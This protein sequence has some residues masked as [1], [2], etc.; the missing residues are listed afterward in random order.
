MLPTL[1]SVVLDI[2]FWLLVLRVLADFVPG[3][4]SSS[5]G[6][7]VFRATEPP[8]SVIRRVLPPVSAGDTMIDL[9]PVIAV[10]VLHFIQNFLR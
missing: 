8:L 1:I 5:V 6:E 10:I 7:L 3:F 2:F 9:S 4:R